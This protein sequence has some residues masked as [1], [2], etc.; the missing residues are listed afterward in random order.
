MRITSDRHMVNVPILCT[1][2]HKSYIQFAK[3]LSLKHEL[4][5]RGNIK[6]DYIIF[7]LLMFSIPI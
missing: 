3:D 5:K 4:I 1:D 6:K 2:S 7:N